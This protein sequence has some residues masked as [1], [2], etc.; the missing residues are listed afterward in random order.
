MI[1]VV[2]AAPSSEVITKID[3]D[4]YCC[5]HHEECSHSV[6]FTLR[7]GYTVIMHKVPK[8]KIREIFTG[9]QLSMPEHFIAVPRKRT[10]FYYLCCC[11][12]KKNKPL[13]SSSS[14][15]SSLDVNSTF[16]AQTNKCENID[17][18]RKLRKKQHQQQQQQ[19][20]TPKTLLQKIKT[21]ETIHAK[22]IYLR[23]KSGNF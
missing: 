1:T 7:S 9:C 8:T 17:D 19:P 3:V 11:L 21:V 4:W 15:S 2:D 22:I 6:I 5:D 20:P 12:K 10:C 18:F 13:N 14:S 23:S 16:S